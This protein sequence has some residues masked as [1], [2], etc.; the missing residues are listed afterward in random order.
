MTFSLPL[1][2]QYTQLSGAGKTPSATTNNDNDFSALGYYAVFATIAFTLVVFL[3]EAYLDFRQRS[4]YYKTEFPSE[5][6]KT[7]GNIDAEREKELKEQSKEVDDDGKKKE[8]E[9]DGDKAAGDGK[10]KQDDINKNKESLDKNKPLLPQLQSKFSKAQS[11]GLDKITF[12]IISSTYNLFEEIIFLLCGYIPYCWDLS[13]HVGKAYFGWNEN[14]NE[15]KIS[16]IFMAVNVIIGTITSL[17][18]ELYSTFRI[19]K[20]HG[21]NKQTPQLFFTD[22]VK[23]LLLTCVFG[24]PFVALLLKIIKMGGE[25]FY[26]YVWAFTFV[27]SVFM[28]TIVPV[29]I[30]PLFNKYEPLP[31][32]SLKEQIYELAG[33]LEFPLTKLFVMDGSKRSSHSN[34]FMFGFFKNKRIVLF[35][36]LMEQVHDDQILAILEHELG[37]W[38]MG[39]T[40]TNFVISQLYTGASFY[41][42]SLCFNSHELY[43][44]FGF[45]DESRPVPTIIALLLFFQTIWAPIDKAL[46]Y[47]MTVF[48]RK[49]EFEADKFSVDLGMSQKLQSGLCKIHLENLGAM[50]P[51]PWYSTY[52]YSH[53]PLVERLSA[54]MAF[55]KKSK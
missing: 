52:H 38:K 20:K 10:T 21:F 45:N 43:R 33:R 18:F 53:P 39:H 16:L 1:T 7:V 26:I 51:D 4:S 24:G 14:D 19:E 35:D 40:V 31:E 50:C 3:F 28:M 8:E 13:C 54:M 9:N 6:S 27:F 55:D 29:V 46:S 11:Y 12:S 23:G 15:I 34:A 32:G 49:C 30:M 48:S 25:S 47:I 22:K 41:C 42:F 17:P 2:P 36:T 37:H 5:L 44:A